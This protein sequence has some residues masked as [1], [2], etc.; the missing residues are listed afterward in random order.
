M[1]GGL[2]RAGD[3]RNNQILSQS[4]SRRDRPFG[5]GEWQEMNHRGAQPGLM[6]RFRISTRQRGGQNN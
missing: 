6:P 5:A 1:F 4:V 2:V 3:I